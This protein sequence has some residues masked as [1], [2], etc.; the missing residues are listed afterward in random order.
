[1]VNSGNRSFGLTPEYGVLPH[2][3]PALQIRKLRQKKHVGYSNKNITG[4]YKKH[5]EFSKYIYSAVLHLKNYFNT[6][7]KKIKLLQC[8]SIVA[9]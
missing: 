1:M 8:K 7:V 5:L 9:I 3:G 4:C 6:K 2:R